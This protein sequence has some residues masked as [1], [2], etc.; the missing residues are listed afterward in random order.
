MKQF[1]YTI[2]CPYCGYQKVDVVF[3]FEYIT[4]DDTKCNRCGKSISM[5]AEI[6]IGNN[7]DMQ[8]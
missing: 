5:S 8:I 4:A 1:K 2:V 3:S 6:G 7:Y